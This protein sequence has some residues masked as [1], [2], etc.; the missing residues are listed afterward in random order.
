[1]VSRELKKASNIKLWMTLLENWIW[2]KRVIIVEI[3]KQVGY[4]DE[5]PHRMFNFVELEIPVRRLHYRKKQVLNLNNQKRQA[6]F[7]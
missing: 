5:D 6:W 4:Q 1:M 2:M 7:S 3:L